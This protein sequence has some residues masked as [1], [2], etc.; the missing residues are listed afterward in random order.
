MTCVAMVMI[1]IVLFVLHC[2]SDNLCCSFLAVLLSCCVLFVVLL[3]LLLL[4]ISNCD[5]VLWDQ[6]DWTRPCITSLSYARSVRCCLSLLLVA[7]HLAVLA[8]NWFQSALLASSAV[9]VLR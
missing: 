1:Y 6:V 9:M 8:P 3:L 7:M 4:L 2:Y 5:C